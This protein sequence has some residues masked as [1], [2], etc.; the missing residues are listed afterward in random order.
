MIPDASA[1]ILAG[2]SGRRLGGISKALLEVGGRTLLARQLE[3]LRPLFA[4]VLL[5]A[6]DPSPFASYGV[7]AIADRFPGK[8]AP[9]GV[10]AALAQADTPWVFCLACDMP[11][12]R[13]EAIEL[14]ASRRAADTEA[15]VP[16]RAGFVE[17]LFAFYSAGLRDALGLA[18]SAGNP[19]LAHLLDAVKTVRV[20]EEEFA[21]A[22][23][24]CR[25]LENVNTPED[26]ARARRG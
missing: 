7:R 6:P 9:G 1:A 16:L 22:D 18:L 4:T 21:R 26:L 12:V 2:G 11:F 23:P 15:V 14:L 5:V 24:G 17:P 13:A 20:T 8:G 3:A 19:S 25:S 10:H